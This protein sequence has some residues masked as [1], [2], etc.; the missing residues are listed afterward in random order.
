MWFDGYGHF[1][2]NFGL[3][4]SLYVPLDTGELVLKAGKNL[5]DKNF[6]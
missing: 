3:E 5:P 1:V 6:L 2:V 4:F